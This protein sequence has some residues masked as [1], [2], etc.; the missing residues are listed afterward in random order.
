MIKTSNNID[1]LKQLHYKIMQ[2]IMQ[3]TL[4]SEFKD[5]E[6]ETLATVNVNN[7]LQNENSATNS[8]GIIA[9]G[10]AASFYAL[11]AIRSADSSTATLKQSSSASGKT[12]VKLPINLKQLRFAKRLCESR[13]ASL[14]SPAGLN[15]SS[16]GQ[17]SLEERIRNRK[18]K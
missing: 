12:D 9:F 2:D 16:N 4:V 3:A 5:K 1:E 13:L 18:V 7:R 17:V 8:S 11:S 6:K 15:E 10:G 14:N